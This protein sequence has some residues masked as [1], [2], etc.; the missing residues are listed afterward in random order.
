[1]SVQ[2]CFEKAA[3][4]YNAALT[5]TDRIYQIDET[6]VQPFY[7]WIAPRLQDAALSGLCWALIALFDIAH[8]LNDVTQ[9]YMTINAHAIALYTFAQDHDPLPELPALCPATVTLALPATNIQGLTVLPFCA[10]EFW[11][12]TVD[13]I[14]EVTLISATPA[15]LALCPATVPLSLHSTS[16]YVDLG[17]TLLTT[18]LDSGFFSG[19]AQPIAQNTPLIAPVAE[20]PAK[21]PKKPRKPKKNQTLDEAPVTAQAV[22]RKRSQRNG[23]NTTQ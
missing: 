12:A 18:I 11:A 15:P 20:T 23:A 17:Y 9:H 16:K 21:T 13:V 5:I 19:A 1:M 22:S 14:P 6:Y 3:T 2:I 7:R 10:E 4:T 8:W